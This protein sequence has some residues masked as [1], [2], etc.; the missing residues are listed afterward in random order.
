[1]T[2][3]RFYQR[4][5]MNATLKSPL[6]KIRGSCGTRTHV[7]RLTSPL[8]KHLSYQATLVLQK[9]VGSSPT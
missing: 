5:T 9:V 1:M 8:L 7:L 2:Y 6:K 4:K 3:D